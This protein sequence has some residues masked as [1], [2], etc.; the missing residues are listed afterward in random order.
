[1]RPPCE[2]VF[3]FYLTIEKEKRQ[4][5]VLDGQ[6]WASPDQLQSQVKEAAGDFVKYYKIDEIATVRLRLALCV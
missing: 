5:L 1:M 3:H 2:G 6:P 4:F